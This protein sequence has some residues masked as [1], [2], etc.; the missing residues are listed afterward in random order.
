MVNLPPL[1]PFQK[2]FIISTGYQQTYQQSK[3][4]PTFGCGIMKITYGKDD[5]Q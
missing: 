2:S 5:K 3:N 1:P 4:S